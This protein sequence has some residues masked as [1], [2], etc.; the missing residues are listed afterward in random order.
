MAS[1][2]PPARTR[3]T[4]DT[5]FPNE[6]VPSDQGFEVQPKPSSNDTKVNNTAAAA[7]PAAPK[8]KLTTT[9]LP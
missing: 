1:D 6:P 5:A 9:Q 8:G 4:T 3:T 2:P 7:P